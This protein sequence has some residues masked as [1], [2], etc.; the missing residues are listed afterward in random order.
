MEDGSKITKITLLRLA[1]IAVAVF[2]ALFGMQ[3]KTLAL[4]EKEATEN[5]GATASIYTA[6]EVKAMIDA[7]P[8][9]SK[10]ESMDDDELNS[11]YEQA[12]EAYDAFE[13]LTEEE[14]GELANELQK[15]TDILDF[16]TDLTET[17][18]PRYI[19]SIGV[20]YSSNYDDA[21]KLLRNNGFEKIDTD[22]NEDA[23]G[24]YV[25]MGFKSTRASY[26]NAITGILLR[27]SSKDD[28]PDH[29]QDNNGVWFDL[30]GGAYEE[31]GTGDG[32]VDLNKGAGGNYIHIYITRD[33]TYSPLTSLSVST[34]STS[35]TAT[36][37]SGNIIN[38]NPKGKTKYIVYQQYDMLAESNRTVRISY[39]DANGGTHIDELTGKVDRPDELWYT[40]VSVPTSVNYDGFTLQHTG[41][42]RQVHGYDPVTT[43]P[44][45]DANTTSVCSWHAT[46][47]ATVQVSYDAN[48]GTGQPEAEQHSVQMHYFY[49]SSSNNW[50]GINNN[51][52]FT[53]PTTTPINSNKCKFLGW[54]TNKNATTA[55]YTAGQRVEFKQNTTLYAVYQ[56]SHTYSDEWSTNTTSH[57]HAA[58]CGCSTAGV[59]S[60]ASHSWSNGKCTVCN[61]V[62]QHNGITTGSCSICG[63]VLSNG[64][65]L[66]APT[67]QNGIYLIYTPAELNWFSVYVNTT[68]AS[69]EGKLMANIDM[70]D[71]SKTKWDPIGTSGSP[72]TGTFDG[73][74]K[75]VTLNFSGSTEYLAM[76]SYVNG[77][78]IQNLTVDGEINASN[79]YAA[80]IIGR[81]VGGE[82]TL[83]N[84]LS[85]VT[86]N[87]TYNGDGT[88]GGLVSIVAGGKMYIKNCGFAGKIIGTNTS[89]CGGMVGWTDKS[90]GVYISNSY[91]AAEF[92]LK[93]NSGNTFAR[94]PNYVSLSN[95][96]YLNALSDPSVATQMSAED[97]KSGKVAYLLNGSVDAGTW[98]QTIGT[99]DYPN[100]S[101]GSVYIHDDC[102][103]KTYTN[104]SLPLEYQNHVGFDSKGFCTACGGYQPAELNNGWYE[105]SNA[106]QLFWFAEHINNG[107]NK[108]SAM[109]K[110]DI[111]LENRA[112]TPIGLYTDD[113]NWGR[114]NTSFYGTFDGQFHVI[115]NLSVDMSETN[116]EAGLFSR[117]AT[118][119]VLKNFGVINATITQNS[120]GHE[121]KGVRTGV[122]AGEIF[123]S[124]VTNVFTAGT[125]SISTKHEQKGGIA[126]ECASSTLTS[127]YTTYGVLTTKV[128]VSSYTPT[129]NRCYYMADT[130]NSSSYGTSMTEAQFTYGEVTYL[131]N[132]GV[133]DG[134]QVW[135]Q[136][137]GTD[138][139]PLFEGMPIYP[140]EERYVNYD[141]PEK[142]SDGIFE[143]QTDQN[144]MAFAQYVNLGTYD[145]NG[146][147]IADIDMGS[148]SWTPIATEA[149]PYTG[150]FDGNGK[151]ISNLSVT[152]T[153]NNQGLFG[154]VNGGTVKNFTVNG[155]IIIAA[156]AANSD[157]ETYNGVQQVGGAVGYAYGGAKIDGITSYVNI[158]DTGKNANV[159]NQAIG[160]VVGL[161]TGSTV[162]NSSSYGVFNMQTCSQL[163]GV[164]GLA[165]SNST[166]SYC[167]NHGAVT[168]T[169]VTHHIGG[170]VASAQTGTAVQY[171]IN[172]GAVTSGSTDCVG[173]V[174]G[175]ANEK[176]SVTYC[177]N[178]GTVNCTVDDKGFVGGILGYVNNSN[179][180]GI[181]NCFNYGSIVAKEG[182]TTYA[183]AII[184]WN[185]SSGNVYSNN[186]YLDTSCAQVSG[187]NTIAATVKTAE[188]FASGEVAY[189]LNGSVDAGTWKQTLGE[190][191]YPNF[192]GKAVYLVYRTCAKKDYTYS[193]TDVEYLGHVYTAAPDFTW[194][195]DYKA[196]IATFSC[197]TDATHAQCQ[198]DCDVT[199]DDSETVF[200]YTATVT[201]EGETYTDTV[202]LEK[203]IVSVQITWTSMEFTF[204]CGWNPDTHAYD[205]GKWVSGTDGGMFTVVN[206]GTEDLT[207]CF[208]F[209]SE[210][211]NVEGGFTEEEL[212]LPAK[213]QATT[214]L[215][216]SGKPTQSVDG[217]IGT[218]TVTIR[219]DSSA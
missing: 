214:T 158:N 219:T 75:K 187:G 121:N 192:L 149:T 203:V 134:T 170:V 196:C 163:G 157:D 73:N 173:G 28:K 47:E 150:T 124:T 9:V 98:K 24:K 50:V 189:L 1:L 114:S 102:E 201:M 8:S 180:K 51:C 159:R 190:D 68:D 110:K 197:Q 56:S 199:I 131:L 194:S 26:S 191:S 46:Y 206:D 137:I 4:G 202:E 5:A 166:I 97:F 165:N 39:F 108:S 205:K 171:C 103:N 208:H 140:M 210:I 169:G 155:T 178:I 23:G 93:D 45:A 42:A 85:T 101:G 218:V 30:V 172:Y 81:S 16:Y 107:N 113:P 69:I 188:Q 79:H 80:S 151:T 179:F 6:D 193:N 216:L 183:G 67:K 104:S 209:E 146:K 52:Y 15:L 130:A 57:W 29:F 143:I 126:G 17:F 162:S 78:T 88:H 55:E 106:G 20:A 125:L 119:G 153:S 111:D 129:I 10:L 2:V 72:Y 33:K 96:Y 59:T 87:S 200:V 27:V 156:T 160:G 64:N 132:G 215:Y 133:T 22:L 176:V 123:T 198:V 32:A 90:A 21:I 12:Q 122:I 89:Y 175:Y 112:W 48:G 14:Q 127:C 109:L 136:T 92:N 161:L 182:K 138:G 66:T 168:S 128:S 207:V 195:N 77:A 7:L 11:V 144:L 186:Y 184:G 43:T 120:A 53:I 118:G 95:C 181:S 35:R 31:N 40:S 148:Y 116:Y 54:S 217:K 185:R 58:T 70:S 76:F 36:D 84:C 60:K 152:A 41:W 19:T 174:I 167:E 82:V 154:V 211:D 38:V 3:Q 105:I 115:Y 100:F 34:S 142:N 117:V 62:C 61:Y 99:D 147:L 49:V 63:L 139:Y 145:A 91:V 44:Y 65:V 83:K 74:G 135:Y 177:G 213:K 37:K 94:N 86:I 141:P 25:C 71:M 13:A 212:S 18:L 204:E 164:V